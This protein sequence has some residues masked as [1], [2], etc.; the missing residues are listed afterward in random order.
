MI[1]AL[2]KS[3]APANTLRAENKTVSETDFLGRRLLDLYPATVP[4]SSGFLDLD[5]T[6]SIYW[7]QSGNPYGVPAFVFHGGPGEGSSPIHRRFYDPEHY[8]I[9]LFDQRGAGRSSPLGCVH[10]NT[11]D[12][13]VEDIEALRTH[14]R[15]DRMHIMGG[16]WG[17]TLALA[18]AVC[19][20][21][22]C[23][24]LTL[25]GIF[26]LQQKEIDWFLYGLRRIYPEAWEKFSNFIPS[27]ERDDLLSAYHKRLFGTDEKIAQEAAKSWYEYESSC[28]YFLPRTGTLFSKD[29][30]TAV[31]AMVKLEAHYFM[32][33][34]VKLTESFMNKIDCIRSI[35]GTIIQGRYDV[36]CP[37]ET[38]YDLHIKWPEADYVVVPDGGHSLRNPS[39]RSRLIEATEHGKRLL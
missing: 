34:V 10:N 28:A 32:N 30:Y 26:L 37:I 4:Y 20:P 8:R 36:L 23:I 9:I 18:Y 22:R 17:S 24:S 31:L 7:E 33:E 19:H 5:E 38:A 27:D 3:K 25:R 29:Q 16:S 21:Q 12:H 1:D 15:V 39:I 14:L 6:H 35:P 11:L 13:L 2:L